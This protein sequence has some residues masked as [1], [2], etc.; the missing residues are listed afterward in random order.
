MRASTS[1]TPPARSRRLVPVS[2]AGAAAVLAPVLWLTG[3][4]REAPQ[5][6]LKAPGR[7]INQGWFD[8]TVHDARIVNVEPP[9]GTTPQRR[10]EVRM[11]VVNKGK[12]TASLGLS[13]FGQGV[14]ARTAKGKWVKPEDVA[15]TAA[16][17]ATDAVQPGLPVEAAVRWQLGPQETPATFTVG[18]RK[19]KYGTGFTDTSFQ[20]RVE[21]DD[22]AGLAGRL[23]LPVGRS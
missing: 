10:L 12:E 11:R 6:P 4:L 13:G 9:F 15:G 16:G 5:E 20:W 17:S 19:W 1:T 7:P 18:L 14:A 22:D 21:T 8:V 3:G 2:A 23:T